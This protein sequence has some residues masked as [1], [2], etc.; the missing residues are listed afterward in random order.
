MSN[1]QTIMRTQ[2]IPKY[3]LGNSIKQGVTRIFKYIKSKQKLEKEL[4]KKEDELK[5]L[6]DQVK[7]PAVIQKPTETTTV[8]NERHKSLTNWIKEH[9]KTIIGTGVGV[10]ATSHDGREFLWDNTK[11][12]WDWWLNG[13]Q[14]SNNTET[15]QPTPPIA[16]NINEDEID[17]A[18]EKSKTSS[19]IDWKAFNDRFE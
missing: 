17:A 13:S 8:A 14:N 11:K 6:Q 18:I 12:A 7:F 19:E 5:T 2:L 3:G 10:V 9:P 16:P 4:K 1:T 15:K